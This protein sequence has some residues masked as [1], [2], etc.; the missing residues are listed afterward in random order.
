MKRRGLSVIRAIVTEDSKLSGKCL[1]DVPFRDLYKAAVI[2]IKKADKSETP[3][4]S[5]VVLAPG[6]YGQNH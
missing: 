3:D 1:G 2:A 5:S 4:M 6:R